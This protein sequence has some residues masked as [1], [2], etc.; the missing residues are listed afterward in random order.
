MWKRQTAAAIGVA[1]IAASCSAGGV[2]EPAGVTEDAAGSVADEPATESRGDT[3]APDETKA[4]RVVD[5]PEGDSEPVEVEN[6]PEPQQDGDEEEPER[7]AA[8]T[9]ETVENQDGDGKEPERDAAETSETVE[10]Q[11]GDGKEPERDAA[12]TSET[13]E[14]QDGDGK[15]PE[16]DAAET[17]ETVENQDGDGKEP[18]RD[19]A[20]T[21]ETV[22][23]QD[24]DGKEPETVTEAARDGSDEDAQKSEDTTGSESEAEDGLGNDVPDEAEQQEQEEAAPVEEPEPK[25]AAALVVDPAVVAGPGIYR[26]VIEGTGFTAG[27]TV[28]VL[29]CRIPGDALTPDTPA[30]AVSAAIGGID[31]SDCD[32]GTAEPVVVDDGGSFS[33]QREE[34]VGGNFAWAASNVEETEKA[35]AAVLTQRAANEPEGGHPPQPLAGMVPREHSYWDY[36]ICAQQGPPWPSDCYPPSEWEVAQDLTDCILGPDFDAG[37]NGIC[38]TLQPD[39]RPRWTTEV[40]RWTSWCFDR[41]RGNCTWLLF[42]MKWALDYLG[43]HPWCV[44]NEYQER[45][46]SYERG[47]GGGA[48]DVRNLYGWHNCATVIDPFAT[49]P[50]IVR[51]NDSGFLLSDT[52]TLAEQCRAVLPEDVELESKDRQARQEFG[53]DC[54]AW[55]QWVENRPRASGYRD[56][57]RSARLAE[58]W[59][60]HHHGTP[61]RYASVK[62]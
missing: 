25:A 31:R 44:L 3:G 14:N 39:E 52:V 35:G 20:E 23:N 36:P 51:R 54:D 33:V 55:A 28:Y 40:A 57:D 34:R 13:V 43:A 46:V 2:P 56:C 30:E 38:P 50:A 6:V 32:L 11:D 41:P 58:E 7:D 1:L 12:E 9:S 24:G 47:E 48:T 62:C 5:D 29:V 16:R 59:M 27:I 37:V 26:F 8:E 4:N 17:S 10:N 21:S 45:I 53:S 60:E 22:E 19:A 61:K 42:E 15:E 49:P 18:E